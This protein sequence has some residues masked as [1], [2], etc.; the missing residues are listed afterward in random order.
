L[1]EFRDLPGFV[2]NISREHTV[3][4]YGDVIRDFE[5]LAE[6]LGLECQVF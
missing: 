5:I 1:L 2:K 4:L 6:V 3:L